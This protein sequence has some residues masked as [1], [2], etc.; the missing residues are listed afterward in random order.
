MRITR[1]I[2]ACLL[3][4]IAASAQDT[5]VEE[6]DPGGL[7]HP[8][9][10]FP[11]KFN[12]RMVGGGRNSG[13]EAQTFTCSLAELNERRGRCSDLPSDGDLEYGYPV[14]ID[15]S[16]P[17]RMA[18]YLGSDLGWRV[19]AGS[20]A[21]TTQGLAR[22]KYVK[23]SPGQGSMFSLHG[24]NAAQG[25]FMGISLD[26]TDYAGAQAGGDEGLMPLVIYL[27]DHKHPATGNVATLLI[28]DICP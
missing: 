3:V 28:R 4:A 11:Y 23:R 5:R 14:R 22:A 12:V 9:W 13:R 25:D 6:F 17:H 1:W 16:T 26:V 7:V 18:E 27:R 10:A 8:S 20:L 2:A 15:D 21:K 19:R 24:V